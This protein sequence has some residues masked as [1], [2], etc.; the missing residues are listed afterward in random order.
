M[1]RRI[2]SQIPFAIAL[3]PTG[4]LVALAFA[5]PGDSWGSAVYVWIVLMIELTMSM[6]ALDLHETCTRLADQRDGAA[7]EYRA[8]IAQLRE[9]IARDREDWTSPVSYASG[10]PSYPDTVPIETHEH[11]ICHR[12]TGLHP[13]TLKHVCT[14][15]D[16]VPAGATRIQYPAES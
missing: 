2:Q 1:N 6:V 15:P 3:A 14:P 5:W 7:E 10:F 13:V 11:V 16:G 4:A 9:Q 12:C 8:K